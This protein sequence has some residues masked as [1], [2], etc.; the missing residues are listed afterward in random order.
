MGEHVSGW[1]EKI[2]SPHVERGGPVS[3]DGWMD[4]WMKGVNKPSRA[5]GGE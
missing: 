4:G 5:G 1:R 3:V 2:D